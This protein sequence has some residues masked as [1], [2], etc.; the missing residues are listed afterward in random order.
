MKGE[1]TKIWLF[2]S[3]D[4]KAAEAYLEKQASE[5]YMLKAVRTPWAF[6][7]RYAVCEPRQVKYCIDG[8]R[9]SAEEKKEY[10]DFAEDGGWFKA[11]ELPGQIIF[12]SRPGEKPTPMQSDWKEE[13]RSIR[14]GLWKEDLPGG[15]IC[16]LFIDL[17]RRLKL[18]KGL[19]VIF[20]GQDFL[21]TVILLLAGVMLAAILGIFV[22]AVWFYLRSE[23]ALRT[24]RP[25]AASSERS[26]RFWRGVHISLQLSLAVIFCTNFLNS[27]IGESTRG[28]FLSILIAVILVVILLLFMFPAK[29]ILRNTKM[30]KAIV[31]IGITGIILLLV[32]CCMDL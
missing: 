13:Y 26:G 16:L 22:R 18:Y 32:Q 17:L 25:I 27:I 6:S 9:G 20:S 31:G 4:Y 15:I 28:D 12:V 24:E 11:A 29:R 2:G 21:S 23:I 14:A 19:N 8:F 1:V 30:K 5:G 10:I 3:L 7:A